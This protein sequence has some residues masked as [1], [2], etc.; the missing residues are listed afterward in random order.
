MNNSNFYIQ[1]KK[2]VKLIGVFTWISFL[3]CCIGT[4]VLY[5]FNKFY[6]SLDLYKASI[7]IFR[8]GLLS[9]I[10]SVIFGYAFNKYINE[11]KY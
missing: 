4:S 11:L 3:I 5:I 7:I 8:T 10:F 2:I 9:A 1:D 6:I